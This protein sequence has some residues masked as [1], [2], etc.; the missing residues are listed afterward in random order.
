VSAKKGS[1]DRCAEFALL[2]DSVRELYR[3]PGR[4]L[5]GPWKCWCPGPAW[6][7]SAL[8][9]RLVYGSVEDMSVGEDVLLRA[10]CAGTTRCGA[11][12]KIRAAATS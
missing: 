4:A 2:R 5:R 8:T 6:G 11:S 3:R 7:L 10:D 12:R 1:H 9:G